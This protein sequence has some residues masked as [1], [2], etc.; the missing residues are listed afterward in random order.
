[1]LFFS[2]LISNL[3]K[4]FSTLLGISDEEDDEKG[5]GQGDEEEISGNTKSNTFN[6]KWAWILTI[7]E[8][9]DM[10]HV[11]WA[12][13]FKMEVREYLNIL[14]FCKDYYQDQKRQHEELM[15]KY[16]K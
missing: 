9:A 10:V 12:T 14:S 15:R 6:E 16:K 8:V 4:G 7:K 3:N 5:E 13:V 2:K 11:D 1:M